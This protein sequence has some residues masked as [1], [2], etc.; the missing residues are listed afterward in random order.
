MSLVSCEAFR[1]IPESFFSRKYDKH[2]LM[3]ESFFLRTTIHQSRCC[4]SSGCPF[5]IILMASADPSFLPQHVLY[6]YAM[7][8]KRARIDPEQSFQLYIGLDDFSRTFSFRVP[9]EWSTFAFDDASISSL[10]SIGLPLIAKLD[11]PWG[12]VAAHANLDHQL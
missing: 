1:H 12:R 5:C 8:S 6:G 2:D 9:P 11:E 4:A 10:R 7:I 3:P